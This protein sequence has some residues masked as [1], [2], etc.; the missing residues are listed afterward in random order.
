M[1]LQPWQIIGHDE[2]IFCK[3][4]VSTKW[5][6]MTLLL[7]LLLEERQVKILKRLFFRTQST[8]C[9]QLLLWLISPITTNLS[10]FLI[11]KLPLEQSEL[12]PDFGHPFTKNSSFIL[13]PEKSGILCL[14]L[15]TQNNFWNI[16][17]WLFV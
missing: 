4:F 16:I 12:F 15:N 6:K 9:K 13:I 14:T 2:K 10:F 11:S 8:Y 1:L 17:W 3:H 7:F 5:R